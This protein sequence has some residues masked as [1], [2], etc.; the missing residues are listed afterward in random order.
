MNREQ[1]IEILEDHLEWLHE[2]EIIFKNEIP[3]IADRLEQQPEVGE[4]I[5]ETLI[6][7]LKDET[8]E[9]G[10]T[11]ENGG[12]VPW[13]NVIPDWTIAEIAEKLQSPHP[14]PISEERIKEVCKKA[15]DEKYPEEAAD[16]DE[17]WSSIHR[18]SIEDCIYA[19][20]AALTEFNKD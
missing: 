16:K 17:L 13:W 3:L 15:M 8:G 2:N 7:A 11:L 10:N 14:Q 19:V 6:K 18:E 9:D 1:I 12:R 5:K 20:K 4:G